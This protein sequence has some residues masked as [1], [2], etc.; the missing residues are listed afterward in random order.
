MHNDTSPG[1]AVKDGMSR[2]MIHTHYA[3]VPRKYKSA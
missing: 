2:R 3:R 1:L